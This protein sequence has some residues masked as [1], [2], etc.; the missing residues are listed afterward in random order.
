VGRQKDEIRCR[1]R[2]VDDDRS[3]ARVSIRL[4]GTRKSARARGVK[5]VRVGLESNRR[6]GRKAKV[7]VRYQRNGATT[8]A[9][10][11]LGRTVKVNAR[12]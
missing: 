6:I 9:V 1:V 10:V 3:A 4:A 7:I 2:S 11:R 12:R 8:R 5:T